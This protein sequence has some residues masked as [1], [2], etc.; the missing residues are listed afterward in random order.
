MITKLEK[1]YM[2]NGYMK[3]V[4]LQRVEEWIDNQ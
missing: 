4:A 1:V 2:G 3:D